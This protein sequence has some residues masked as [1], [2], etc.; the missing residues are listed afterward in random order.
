M[1]AKRQCTRLNG[2]QALA[3]IFKECLMQPQLQQPTREADNNAWRTVSTVVTWGVAHEE[4]KSLLPMSQ[5]TLQAITQE[6]LMVCF[7]AGTYVWSTIEVRHRTYGYNPPLA[8]RMGISRDTARRSHQSR[9]CR[10]A[11]CVRCITH[12]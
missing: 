7:S 3:A 2:T 9:A 1:H 6:M 5:E 11:I 10:R 12:T 8:M 4:E